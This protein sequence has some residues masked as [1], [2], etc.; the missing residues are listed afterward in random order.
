MAELAALGVIDPLAMFWARYPEIAMDSKFGENL[1]AIMPPTIHRRLV[2]DK[3]SDTHRRD[4]YSMCNIEKL[5]IP[6]ADVRP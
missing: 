5:R 1:S 6:A 3:P 2:T 4:M